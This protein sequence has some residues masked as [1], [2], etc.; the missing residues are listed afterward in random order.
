[1]TRA[2]ARSAKR[3]EVVE[4]TVVRNEPVGLVAWIYNIPRRT[5]F[6]WLARYRNGGWD[7]LK[8]GSRRGRPRKLSGEDMQWVYEAITMGRP[9]NHKFEF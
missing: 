9:L 6:D 8:E 7:A 5:I 2:E 3:K 4:A 1:M